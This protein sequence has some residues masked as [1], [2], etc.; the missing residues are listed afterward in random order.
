MQIDEGER[1]LMSKS[2]C[3]AAKSLEE[4]FLRMARGER[5]ASANG[6]RPL[7]HLPVQHIRHH[8]GHAL[9]ADKRPPYTG[10]TDD[11]A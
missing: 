8:R 11:V 7:P 5:P 9:R 1:H 10:D 6:L 4:A 2:S 3:E